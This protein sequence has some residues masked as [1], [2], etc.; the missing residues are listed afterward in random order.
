M[1][2]ENDTLG[3]GVTT[4][5]SS[6]AP[7]QEEEECISCATKESLKESR[8]NLALTLQDVAANLSTKQVLLERQLD[9][10]NL[11][12]A[13]IHETTKNI[14]YIEQCDCED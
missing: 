10:A 8:Y 13:L 11:L 14:D 9:V 4:P 2:N 12:S 6:V 5:H 3:V 7:Y 1:T